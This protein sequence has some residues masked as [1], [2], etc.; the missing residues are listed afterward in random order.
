MEESTS[1]LSS[2]LW[3][4]RNLGGNATTH[5]HP[6]TCIK[7]TNPHEH[8]ESLLVCGT[9]LCWFV[10]RIDWCVCQDKVPRPPLCKACTRA[11][12]GSWAFSILVLSA[13]FRRQC[14][15]VEIKQVIP[16]CTSH[17]LPVQLTQREQIHVLELCDPGCGWLIN[18][19][20]NSGDVFC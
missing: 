2:F 1:N 17:S 3:W 13:A 16:C 9:T 15:L 11:D 18:F 20:E 10:L 7:Q 14:S 5:S 19:R 6:S 4:K 8:E 12:S